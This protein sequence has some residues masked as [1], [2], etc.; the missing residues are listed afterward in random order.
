MNGKPMLLE[1]VECKE[2]YLADNL[3]DGYKCPKCNGMVVGIGFMRK[4]FVSDIEKEMKDIQYKI[5][6]AK[7]NGLIRKYNKSPSSKYIYGVDLAKGKDFTVK[8]SLNAEE[9]NKDLIEKVT[10]EL[11]KHQRT[12]G[13]Y[14]QYSY[15]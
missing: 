5:D 13:D 9:F 7:E 6:K 8:V 4:I 15:E 14:I 10:E 2:T 12:I 3:C 1:C 11:R